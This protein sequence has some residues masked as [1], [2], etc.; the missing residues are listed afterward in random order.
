MVSDVR[1]LASHLLS[2]RSRL[3]RDFDADTRTAIREAV[4]ASERT[5]RG[6][7][8]FAV[9]PRLAA[10]SVWKGKTARQRALELF[11]SLGVWDTAENSGILVY[12]LLADRRVEIV[13]DRG[14]A[15]GVTEEQWRDVCHTI[16]GAYRERRFRE[17]S[18]QG[19]HECA[20]H[21]ARLFP[22]RGLD[23]N[24]LTDEVVVL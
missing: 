22:L 19:V 23:A 13:A 2:F 10:A 15:G 5:H 18:V 14:Y 24:E 17:G 12:V 6:E 16:E 7:I 9:E 3:D 8:R 1:R 21:A 11:S 4:E 20:R